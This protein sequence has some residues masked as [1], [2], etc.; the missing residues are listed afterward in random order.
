MVMFVIFIVFPNRHLYPLPVVDVPYVKTQGYRI[1][2]KRIPYILI[3]L[4]P[5]QVCKLRGFLYII[6]L[7]LSGFLLPDCALT[8]IRRFSPTT[9]FL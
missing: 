2:Y 7:F 6:I 4:L 1:I 3:V 8:G 5:P 9:F